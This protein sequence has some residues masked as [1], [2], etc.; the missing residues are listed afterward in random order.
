MTNADASVPPRLCDSIEFWQLCDTLTVVQAALLIA[1]EAPLQPKHID[2]Y[3]PGWRH[4]STGFDA[5]TS[6]LVKAIETKQ[7]AADSGGHTCIENWDDSTI[8]VKDLRAWL[9]SR[10]FT[11]GFF[12]P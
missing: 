8:R 2:K 3:L 11:K 5:V 9:K 12:F 6:A 4:R 7:L 10:G 1:G